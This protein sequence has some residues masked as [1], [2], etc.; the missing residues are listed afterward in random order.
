M[1]MSFNSWQK[2][3]QNLEMF[4]SAEVKHKVFKIALNEDL[5]LFNETESST[6]TLMKSV[7]LTNKMTE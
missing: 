1:D 2:G 4:E 7:F 3:H 5:S 6:D